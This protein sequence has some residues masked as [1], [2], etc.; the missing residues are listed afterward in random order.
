[1]YPTI[2]FQLLGFKDF[3][4]DRYLPGI[5]AYDG[6]WISIDEAYLK[7]IDATP[8]SGSETAEKQITA[9][10]VSDLAQS[11]SKTTTEYLLSSDPNKAVLKQKSFVSR[12]K[13]D[14]IDAYHYVVSIDKAHTDNYCKA[15]A[16]N[17][18]KSKVAIKFDGDQASR[19]KST[20]SYAQDCI[21]SFENNISSGKDVHL[22]IDMQYKIIYKIKVIDAKKSNNFVEFGQ[23]YTGGDSFKLFANVKEVAAAD[24]CPA[25]A[26]TSPSSTSINST[27]EVNP[28]NTT[29]LLTISGEGKSDSSDITT[30]KFSLNTK[31]FTGKINTDKPAETIPTANVLK[32]LGLD[33]A[34][35]DAVRGDSLV[36][37]AKTEA[38]STAVNLW[39]KILKP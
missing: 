28:K 14:N 23:H 37:G 21:S 33:T 24:P 6:K 10:D 32:K 3:E 19:K 26:D 12:E 11:F 27:L 17:I 9:T 25:C 8:T 4:L 15:L 39:Q 36:L 13:V 31:P 35:Q 20:D 2:Y 18:Y 30:Y 29:T 5:N 1:L 16:S 34:T 22:W 7:S 38:P